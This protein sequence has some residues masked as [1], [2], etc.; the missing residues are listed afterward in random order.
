LGS[1]VLILK[2]RKKYS[3]KL[4]NKT[5]IEWIEKVATESYMDHV[6]LRRYLIDFGLLE[7]DPAGHWY[8]VS[9]SKLADLFEDSIL[10]IDPFSLVKDFREEREARRKKWI[11]K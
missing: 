2:P 5:I 9:E 6:T 8:Y 1:I 7:R 11:K 3:E 10:K 4:I